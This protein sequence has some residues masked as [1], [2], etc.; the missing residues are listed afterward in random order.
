M[1]LRSMLLTAA[2]GAAFVLAGASTAQAHNTCVDRMHRE[3][4]KLQRD[5]RRHG[6]WSHQ[7][8]HRR[9]KVLRLRR[10]CGGAGLWGWL[11][12]RRG[13][14]FDDR[15]WRSRDRD[16]DDDDRWFDNRR[17]RQRGRGR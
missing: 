1:T 8:Q 17:G 16:W 5:I 10:E 6:Y 2:L 11:D 15:R 7:A 3:E 4:H 12:G 9:E 14:R 13:D